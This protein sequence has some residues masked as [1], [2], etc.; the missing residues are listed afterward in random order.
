MW[1]HPLHVRQSFFGPET[2]VSSTG[3]GAFKILLLT[4]VACYESF[5][6]LLIMV[7]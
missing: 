6:P 7:F 2:A 5:M 3:T 1:L 4:M